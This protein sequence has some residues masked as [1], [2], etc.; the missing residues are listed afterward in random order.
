MVVIIFPVNVVP[1]IVPP[2]WLCFQLR[3]KSM[4]TFIKNIKASIDHYKLYVYGLLTTVVL[5]YC[6]FKIFL[7]IITKEHIIP[8][9][10]KQYFDTV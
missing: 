9:T 1:T 3:N 10:K 8:P 6:L 7:I 4:I 2:V 5:F